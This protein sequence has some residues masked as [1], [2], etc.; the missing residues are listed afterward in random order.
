MI[1]PED[2]EKHSF[3]CT[4]TTSEILNLEEGCYL[5]E[6]LYKIGKLEECLAGLALMSKKTENKTCIHI[7][8]KYCRA[9]KTQNLASIRDSLQSLTSW[10]SSFRGTISIRVYADRLQSLMVE[11]VRMVEEKEIETTRYELDRIK[12]EVEKYKVRT[13]MIKKGILKTTSSSKIR[14]FVKNVEEAK[15]DGNC[16][17]ST[18]R[19]FRDEESE[20]NPDELK[21]VF[22]SLCLALKMKM[23]QR[24]RTAKI[25]MQKLFNEAMSQNVEPEKWYDFISKKLLSLSSY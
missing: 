25:N 19:I 16:G 7:L 24:T 10:L 23:P 20:N 12:S 17:A 6:L 13:E 18:Q 15:N 2:V 14:N 9:C 3:E 11:I 4:S 8:L 1:H 22:Y 21:K 5:N